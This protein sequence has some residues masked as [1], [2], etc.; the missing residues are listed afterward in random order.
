MLKAA[1]AAAFPSVFAAC[2]LPILRKSNVLSNLQISRDNLISRGV[3]LSCQVAAQ[4]MVGGPKDGLT[5]DNVLLIALITSFGFFTLADITTVGL[6]FIGTVVMV[7]RSLMNFSLYGGEPFVLLIVA[8][9]V[10]SILASFYRNHQHLSG[11][12]NF[13]DTLSGIEI[14]SARACVVGMLHTLLNVSDKEVELLAF[15]GV[16]IGAFVMISLAIIFGAVGD[17][18]EAVGSNQWQMTSVDTLGLLFH[19]VFPIVLLLYR[20]CDKYNVLN[21]FQENLNS[22]FG[23]YSSMVLNASIIL[24]V[25]VGIG[26]PVLNSLSPISSYL[27]AR[28]YLNGQPSTR[29]V[30]I[31]VS[32]SDIFEETKNNP[33]LFKEFLLFLKQQKATLNVFAKFSDTK[34]QRDMLKELANDGHHIGIS[35]YSHHYESGAI[36]FD[37]VLTVRDELAAITGVDPTW[38]T[39]VSGHRHPF[40]LKACAKTSMRVCYWSTLCHTGIMNQD[41]CLED[42]KRDVRAKGGGNI[43]FFTK[44]A[45][46]DHAWTSVISLIKQS[47]V[48]LN[49]IKFEARGLDEVVKDDQVLHLKHRERVS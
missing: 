21:M 39:P 29:K 1:F 24:S 13:A 2:I 28:S 30:A 20:A 5:S 49:E 42:I 12:I 37:K 46:N 8:M 44:G 43:I 32:F 45:T 38:Y 6:V 34:L 4:T 9:I 48:Y 23:S 10:M 47:I 7:V 41:K 14:T 27:F 25:V 18:W 15:F 33:Q 35:S 22:E 31:S 11:S 3:F 19:F 36:A 40:A 17:C 26:M 16:M